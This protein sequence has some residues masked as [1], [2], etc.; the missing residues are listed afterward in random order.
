MQDTLCPSKWT[1][2]LLSCFQWMYPTEMRLYFWLY[3]IIILWIMCHLAIFLSNS[4]AF[5]GIHSAV[6]LA[7]FKF[8]SIG[9]NPVHMFRLL[10]SCYSLLSF[11]QPPSP[12]PYHLK[13]YSLKLLLFCFL[14]KCSTSLTILQTSQS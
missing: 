8:L 11:P 6:F 4:Q 2:T 10:F 9:G 13:N 12:W 1:S 3:V 14:F 5:C 7:R